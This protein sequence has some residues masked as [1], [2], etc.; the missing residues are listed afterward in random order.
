MV[1]SFPD[2][3]YPSGMDVVVLIE[4]CGVVQSP[5]NRENHVLTLATPPGTSPRAL[6]AAVIAIPVGLVVG[7]EV[8]QQL[9]ESHRQRT[10]IHHTAMTV[11]FSTAVHGIYRRITL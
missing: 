3:Y 6:L 2:D 5:A 8:A 7:Q 1:E 4:R 11:V 9:D 10:Q